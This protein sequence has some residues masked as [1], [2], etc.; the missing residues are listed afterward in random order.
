D[1]DLF[2]G[3]KP[4][5]KYSIKKGSRPTGQAEEYLMTLYGDNYEKLFE[6]SRQLTNESYDRRLLRLAGIK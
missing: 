2:K 4:L 1:A 3:D 6:G 5:S